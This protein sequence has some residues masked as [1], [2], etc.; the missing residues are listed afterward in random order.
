MM[1]LKSF[2]VA[3]EIATGTGSQYVVVKN[4]TK[5]TWKRILYGTKNTIV[6]LSE[7][8]SDGTD[9]GTKTAFETGDDCVVSVE[10][11]SYVASGT[12]A[13]TVGA[14]KGTIIKLTTTNSSSSNCPGVTI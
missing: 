6:N 1:V 10:G 7:L 8:S 11:N 2:P 9:G 4:L 3:V 12:F 13:F 14:T 5:G